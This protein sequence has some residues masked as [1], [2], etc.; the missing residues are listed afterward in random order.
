MVYGMEDM[1][2]LLKTFDSKT[3]ARILYI[4]VSLIVVYNINNVPFGWYIIHDMFSEIRVL[5]LLYCKSHIVICL[6][7]AHTRAIWDLADLW[8]H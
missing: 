6:K 4:P 2:I 1:Y 5:S 7:C 8:P 3:G